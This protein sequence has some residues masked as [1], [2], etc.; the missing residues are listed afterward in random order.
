MFLKIKIENNFFI[1][2][3]AFLFF[4]FRNQKIVLKNGYQRDLNSLLMLLATLIVLSSFTQKVYTMQGL[5]VLL[6]L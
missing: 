3:H 1:I 6:V 5:I 2:K 4:C